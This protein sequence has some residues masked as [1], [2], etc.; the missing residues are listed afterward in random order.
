VP[1]KKLGEAELAAEIL[2]PLL[3][4]QGVCAINRKLEAK[5]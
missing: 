1:L 2:T 4:E 5:S 3:S